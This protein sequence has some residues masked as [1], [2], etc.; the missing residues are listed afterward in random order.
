MHIA[1][2]AD[3]CHMCLH[4]MAIASPRVMLLWNNRGDH[5]GGS[6]RSREEWDAGRAF[7]IECGVP[8]MCFD[9]TDGSVSST[10]VDHFPLPSA[11]GQLEA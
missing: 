11:I 2:D 4:I 3:S 1:A 6:A 8:R 10:S 5:S 9:L 7:D